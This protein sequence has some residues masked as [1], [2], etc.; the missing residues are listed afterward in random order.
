MTISGIK[1]SV[2]KTILSQFGLF[3][4]MSV[5]LSSLTIGVLVFYLE[6]AIWQ[7]RRHEAVVTASETILDFVDRMTSSMSYTAKLLRAS[8]ANQNSTLQL[9]LE[10]NP[11]FVE[12]VK[13]DKEGNIID[14]VSR[15]RPELANAFLVRQSY[16]FEQVRIQNHYV[17]SVEYAADDQPYII[18]AVAGEEELILAARISMSVLSDVVNQIHFGSTGLVYVIDEQGYLLAHPDTDLMKGYVTLPQY[19]HQKTVLEQLGQESTGQYQN[20]VNQSVFGTARAIPGTGWAVVAEVNT[21]EALFFG[22]VSLLIELAIL[23]IFGLSSMLIVSRWLNRSIFLP[24]IALRDGAEVLRIGKL[25]VRIPLF[26][27]DEIGAVAKSF[28]HMADSL[29][30]REKDLI[31]TSLEFQE[32]V[33][34][35]MQ[36]QQ[37]LVNLN[38][39]LEV[40]VNARTAELSESNRQ[41]LESESKF[42]GLVDNIPAI[43]Y[44]A[45]LTDNGPELFYVS[46]QVEDM[47]GYSEA[48]WLDRTSRDRKIFPDDLPMIQKFFD[49]FKS[50]PDRY[51]VEYRVISHDRRVVWIKDQ[52]VVMTLPGGGF[53][54]LGVMSNITLEREKTEIL[55][56]QALHDGLTGLANRSLFM[57]RLRHIMKRAQRHPEISF[58]VFFMD[59]D[60]FKAVN[61]T[62]GHAAG[63][64][65]LI[66]VGERIRASVR[67]F[68]TVARY[69][70]DEFIV[71]LEDTKDHETILQLR[72]RIREEIQKPYHIHGGMVTLGVSIGMVRSDEG[73]ADPDELIQRADFLMYENKTKRRENARFSS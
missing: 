45:N 18:I 12:V 2:R 71:L 56:Q 20:L 35:R 41:L 65:V 51:T 5:L 6:N 49:D 4:F 46:P 16:W 32:E 73:I 14:Y 10:S 38:A 62:F 28:N 59:L 44:M 63:D 64:S 54:I 61:D 72:D 15:D 60:G 58:A 27:E 19:A 9:L 26:N 68:D 21:N 43:T 34:I 11:A 17:G 57:D 30:D 33:K 13:L 36:A 70:G 52:G 42:H 1:R 3:V 37:E 23:F 69:G 50:G 8:S 7:E 40:R 55:V 47:F 67:E 53:Y 25:N 29:E 31:Q 48:E 39:N 66:L 22:R 24:L